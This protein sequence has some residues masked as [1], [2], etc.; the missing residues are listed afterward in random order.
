MTPHH[1]TNIFCPKCR[2]RT[3][4]MTEVWTGH[5]IEWGVVDGGLDGTEGLLKPGDP[6]KVVATCKAC[7]HRWTLRGV[8][9]ITDVFPG[10]GEPTAQ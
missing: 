8:L 10:L 9:Q 5:T 6:N 3:L 1:C 4:L 7:G 2:G